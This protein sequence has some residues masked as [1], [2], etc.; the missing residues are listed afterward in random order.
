MANV[1]MYLYEGCEP[2][3]SLG[4][5]DILRRCGATVTMYGHTDII[6]MAHGIQVKADTTTLPSDLLDCIVLPGGMGWK[7]LQ[8]DPQAKQLTKQ[9]IDAGKIVAAIC[10]AP[11]VALGYW[12]YLDGIKA[13]CYPGAETIGLQKATFVEDRVVVDGQFVTSRG[14]GTALEFGLEIARQ[15]K[16]DAESVMKATLIK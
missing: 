4:T 15:L 5:V 7:N 2:V 8:Q 11:S 12:G 16:L 9:Y 10:A 1:L 13:T 14:P 3:E 6:K